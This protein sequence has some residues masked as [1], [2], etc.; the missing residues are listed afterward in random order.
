MAK[1]RRGKIHPATQVFQDLRI[2]VNKELQVIEDFLPQAVEALS[3]GGRLAIITF[4]SLEDR[5]VKWFFKKID[6]K[7]HACRV[8]GSGEENKKGF[9][10]P[11]K[12]IKIK[13]I[14]KKVIIPKWDE[15]KSN[16]RAR[17]AK[18]RVVEKI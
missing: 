17:S 6:I 16:R 14:N 3:P 8:E 7:A 1:H 11:L 5:I 13:L 9:P 4:H 18:L 10:D 2:A 15:V 12:H